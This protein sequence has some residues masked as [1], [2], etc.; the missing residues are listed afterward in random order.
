MPIAVDR[1]RTDLANYKRL[2]LRVMGPGMGQRDGSAKPCGRAGDQTTLLCR[3]VESAGLG[4]VAFGRDGHIA[5]AT[6]AARRWLQA[7]FGWKI[8]SRRLPPAL[9][10]WKDRDGGDR[11]KSPGV[12]APFRADQGGRTLFVRLLA[13]GG[14]QILVL[15][16]SERPSGAR[17]LAAHLLTPREAEVLSW[18]ADGKTNPEIAQIL[19]VARRTV[20]H[21]LEHIYAKLGVG[22]RTA[23]TVRALHVAH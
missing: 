2:L 8:S 18:V 12:R 19:G 5:L 11:Q 3:A 4:F 10:A 7:Y 9:E 23:A 6:H 15:R 14:E 20:H 16:E 22:T 21:H 13:E 1:A 17:M